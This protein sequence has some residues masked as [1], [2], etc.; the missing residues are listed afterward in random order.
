[1][2]KPLSGER[3][4]AAIKK[5]YPR[6]NGISAL[7]RELGIARQAVQNWDMVPP[8]RVL[9]V[10]ALTGISRHTL[11]PDLYPTDAAL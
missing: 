2:N 11:R 1:M 8:V 3:L 7:A 10:E 5:A 4:R 6:P 9:D